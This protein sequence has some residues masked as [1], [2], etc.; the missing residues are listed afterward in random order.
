MKQQKL[1]GSPPVQQE[2]FHLPYRRA[3]K[4]KTP[5][6]YC[7]F[8]HEKYGLKINNND[9]KSA[10]N[11]QGVGSYDSMIITTPEV[12]IEYGNN[13]VCEQT[14]ECIYYGSEN[15]PFVNPTV[16]NPVRVQ[17]IIKRLNLDF[18][19]TVLDEMYKEN[20]RFHFD[21]LTV[22]KTMIY[23]KLKGHRFLTDVFNDLL[24]DPTLADIL[25]YDTIPSY[26]QLYHFI[27]YRINSKGTKKIFDVL[28]KRVVCECKNKD[29][30]VGEEIVI[31]SSPFEKKNNGDATYNTH[32][33][34][35]GYKW[36]NVRCVHTDI[37]LEYHVST[38]T[39][40]D[41]DFLSPLIYRIKTIH[42]IHPKRM[43]ADGHYSDGKN[44]MRMREYFNIEPVIRI[45][46]N[47]VIKPNVD[48]KELKRQYQ[49][50][51]KSELFKLDADTDYM[52]WFLILHDKTAV[53][54]NF[55]HNQ[56]V[57]MYLRNPEEYQ[58]RYNIREM[59]ERCH[60][61]EKR[62]TEIKN[63]QAIDIKK[64]TT[65]IGMHV[66]SLLCLAL[67]RLQNG[68]AENFTFRGGLI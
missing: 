55:Y 61:R 67:V 51:W 64:F 47:A 63:I 7:Q 19:K 44:L 58:N 3:Y 43:F 20:W 6:N 21:P 10:T 42:D 22:L 11:T 27:T 33:G 54:D 57:E 35:T 31:D 66:I 45:N 65:H 12:I 24:T 60:G 18:L 5:Y 36:H 8:D 32:Y 30:P 4:E 68:V 26:Q 15:L 23:W 25:G 29:I 40:Y 17:E 53:L 46:K 9:P 2:Y 56:M 50:L 34:I 62:H 39:E 1:C 52:K 14:V 28:L 59:I 49:K 38:L 41:G 13:K 37:P 16:E 48:L